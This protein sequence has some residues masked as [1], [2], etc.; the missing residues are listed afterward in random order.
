MEGQ[1]EVA[2]VNKTS[3]KPL[4]GTLKYQLTDPRTAAEFAP[5]WDRAKSNWTVL[6]EI[7]VWYNEAGK[8]LGTNTSKIP[9]VA[10][11]DYTAGPLSVGFGCA[12]NPNLI[13]PEY[14]FGF[15]MHAANPGEKM[16][17]IKTAWGGKT[18]AEDFRPPS[19]VADPQ[20]KGQWATGPN[21]VGHYYT[22][23]MTIVEQIMA[24][25]VIAKMFPDLA[26]L[27]PEIS[28]FGWWVLAL[29]CPLC[30]ASLAAVVAQVPGL[31]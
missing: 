8:T 22:R 24:P 6:P 3:G 30:G 20:G 23:M 25:G 28:G 2:T 31:E 14:G 11:V 19:S 21:V 17:I 10:G 27:E 1:A 15:G 7:K 16:L 9:G 29:R 4:N 13:G 12:G 5:L 26:G 18:I